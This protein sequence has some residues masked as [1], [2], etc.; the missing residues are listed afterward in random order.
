M[1]DGSEDTANEAE[2]VEPGAYVVRKTSQGETTRVVKKRLTE[3]T[4]TEN[5]DVDCGVSAL[6]A[7]RWADSMSARTRPAQRISSYGST[8][9]QSRS[10]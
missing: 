8:Y 1:R 3:R 4:K 6:L 5:H 10:D 7:S 2:E 9:R